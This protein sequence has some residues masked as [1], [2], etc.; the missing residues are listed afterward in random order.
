MQNEVGSIDVHHLSEVMSELGTVCESA[1][2][3]D[4][5]MVSWQFVMFAS[6][7]RIWFAFTTRRVLLATNHNE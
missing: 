1:E 3:E 4:V 2:V 5:F 7:R 6:A